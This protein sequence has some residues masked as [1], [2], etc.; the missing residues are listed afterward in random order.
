[1]K[2]INPATEKETQ[3]LK[4]DH[5]SSIQSKVRAAQEAQKFWGERP[6]SERKEIITRF[7]DLLSENKEELAQILTKEMGKPISQ[8]RGEVGATPARLDWFL[9]N[10]EEVLRCQGVSKGDA[11]EEKITYEPLGVI[12]NISAWNYPYFTGTNVFIPALLT[13][14]AVLYKPSELTSLT[15]LKMAE[16]L[17]RAGTPK[18]IFTPVIGGGDVGAELLK[19]D[20]N[21]VYFTG[22]YATGLKVAEAASRKLMKYQ[23][24]LGGK[25]PSY[26]CEDVDL[27]ATAEAVADGIFYNA[28]QSCCSIERVYVNEKIQEAFLEVFLK[29]V[30]QFKVGDPQDDG[31]YIGPLA[32]E[33]QLKVLEEQVKDAVSKGAKLLRGGKR[34][35]RTGYYF[36]PT[37]LINVDHSMKVMQEESFGPIIGIHTVS[38]DAQAIEK[39]NDTSYGLAASVF[40]KDKKRAEKILMELNSGSVYWNTSDRVVPQLPWTGRRHSGVGSMLSRLGI[41][42]FLQPKAWHLKSVL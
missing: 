41:E 3:V 21:G 30:D 22:S 7:R 24:E 18:E 23:L 36:E 34:M 5:F 11:L 32:R 4:A 27:Q 12:A 37:V 13:G 9:E 39:M 10:T 6:F 28:G 31:V 19:Q 25:D 26:L 33:A 35:D 14:N 40:T 1:M 17:W 16:L 29:Q 42:S 15:G 2:L 38:S 8:A 20:L